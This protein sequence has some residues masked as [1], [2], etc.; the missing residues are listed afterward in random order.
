[1]DEFDNVLLNLS[2]YNGERVLIHSVWV[3]T[4]LFLFFTSITA[5]QILGYIS[6]ERDKEDDF[7]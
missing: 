5:N 7:I 2:N 4:Y 3:D 1:M 6:S